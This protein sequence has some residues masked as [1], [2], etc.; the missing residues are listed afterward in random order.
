[1]TDIQTRRNGSVDIESPVLE[2]RRKPRRPV[3]GEPW[4]Y[5]LNGV[6][7]R[8][9]VTIIIPARNE[10]PNLAALFESLPPVFEVILVDGNSVDGTIEVAQELMPEL[11]VLRQTGRGKGNAMTASKADGGVFLPPPS[12]ALVR[13]AGPPVS[14]SSR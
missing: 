11:T 8:V 14:P 2:E 10:A 1:M 3:P 5:V 4:T 13:K 6:T 12:A 9:A 7:R